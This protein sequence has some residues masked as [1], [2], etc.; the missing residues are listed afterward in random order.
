[1][2]TAFHEDT[3]RKLS[4]QIADD[5]L[6]LSQLQ[7]VDK[8]KL[9]LRWGESVLAALINKYKKAPTEV[10]A[11]NEMC[12]HVHQLNKK[13]W[14]H[15]ETDEKLDRN[16]G[17]MLMLCVSELSEALEGH[18]KDLPDDK[19]PHRKMFEVELAD[20]I[21]RIFDIAGGLGLDLGGAFAEKLEYNKTRPDH[22]VEARKAEGGKKY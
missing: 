4:Q 5:Y 10:E 21:I 18:R 16:V 13:W 14:H 3:K 6:S 15:I 7:L 12:A 19:L 9:K 20:C 2:D 1:M 22:Q 11:L 8:Y 17:E